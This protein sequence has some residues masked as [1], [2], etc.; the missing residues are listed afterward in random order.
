MIDGQSLTYL[1]EFAYTG[2]PEISR[3][4]VTENEKEV[5]GIYEGVTTTDMV[6]PER[7]DRKETSLRVTSL[8]YLG[9]KHRSGVPTSASQ[10][11]G[12]KMGTRSAYSVFVG[13]RGSESST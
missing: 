7:A 5:G 4:P 3:A 2:I 9:S 8:A 13:G 6:S 1:D 10:H 12:G 11:G